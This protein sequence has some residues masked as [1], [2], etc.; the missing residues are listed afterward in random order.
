VVV[1]LAI[2]GQGNCSF[3]IDQGLRT[4]VHSHYTQAFMAED[5]VVPSPVTRPVRAAMP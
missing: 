1:D 5:G 3:V 4:A 2:H